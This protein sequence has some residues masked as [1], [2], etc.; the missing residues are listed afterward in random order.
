MA[1]GT[2]P[3]TKPSVSAQSTLRGEVFCKVVSTHLTP[4]PS[5]GAAKG[6]LLAA[7]HVDML[8]AA[9][10]LKGMS[11]LTQELWQIFWKL[12]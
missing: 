12:G 10:L 7:T 3:S 1:K 4:F 5:L 9:A 2:G 8:L 11:S 6:Q